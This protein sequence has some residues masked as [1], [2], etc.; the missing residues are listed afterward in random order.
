[1]PSS[2]AVA[3]ATPNDLE[4][5]SPEP[6]EEPPKLKRSPASLPSAA[7]AAAADTPAAAASL[8]PNTVGAVVW[9][10]SLVTEK[11]VLSASPSESLELLVSSLERSLESVF[12]VSSSSSSS[13]DS[14]SESVWTSTMVEPRPPSLCAPVLLPSSERLRSPPPGPSEKASFRV[15]LSDEERATPALLERREEKRPPSSSSSSSAAAAVSQP[16]N[17]DL[18]RS[19]SG[20][21][22]LFTL[23]N[24]NEPSDER[25][26]EGATVG[27]APDEENSSLR[28]FS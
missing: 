12:A 6:K 27:R 28:R 9:P 25:A 18:R 13:S 24:E 15:T 4:R 23:A 7:A 19:A 26:K 17:A 22:L 16:E 14:L 2:L 21:V 20:G 11:S 1:M 10:R 5:P 3:S 8:A